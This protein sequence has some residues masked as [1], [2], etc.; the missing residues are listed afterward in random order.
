M[1][2]FAETPELKQKKYLKGQMYKVNKGKDA[3][4]KQLYGDICEKDAE[5]AIEFL[6]DYTECIKISTDASIMEML[7]PGLMAVFMPVAIG[8]LL[9]SK[10][11]AG[12]LVGALS[13]GFMLAVTMSNAG[14][15]WDNAKKYVE[16]SGAKGTDKHDATVVGDTVGD[17]FKD[18]SGPALNILIKLMSVISLV[19]APKLKALQLKDKR[20]VDWEPTGVIIGVIILV[21]LMLFSYWWQGKVDAGYK[22]MNDE[23]V[24]LQQ[25][26]KERNEAKAKAAEEAAESTDGVEGIELTESKPEQEGE[27]ETA[28]KKE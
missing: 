20:I 14:G 7:I 18:T 25:K 27:A 26:F 28:D 11:L 8:F 2:Q 9:T 17:P 5:G 4:G 16:K 10:G 23:L 6:P 15:A 12:M 3:N 21:L 13:S 1:G 19:I 22:Q 24:A